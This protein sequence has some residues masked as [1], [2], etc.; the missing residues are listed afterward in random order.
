MVT[1]IPE[2]GVVS[3]HQNDDWLLQNDEQYQQESACS[4]SQQYTD[5]G[6]VHVHVY[7]EDGFCKHGEES[8]EE[9]K[10]YIDETVHSTKLKS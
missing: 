4:S 8:E 7:P 6:G 9:V 1:N 5:A 2:L 3:T 10:F